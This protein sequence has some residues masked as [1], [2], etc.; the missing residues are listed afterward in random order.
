MKLTVLGSYGPYP[1][2]GGACPGYLLEHEGYAVLLEC[3]NGVISRLQQFI[4]LSQLQAIVIS[5]L[6]S[7]H[8]SDLFILR[9]ALQFS[10]ER[11]LL[12]RPLPIFAPPEPAGEYL[13]LPYKD[14]YA[15]ETLAEGQ[16]LQLGPFT[17]LFLETK[18]PVLCYAMAISIQGEK[19]LVYSADTEY[20]PLLADFA[21]GATLFLCEANLLEEDL[22][23]GAANHLS[24]AQAATLARE[25]GVEALL[26]THLH[27]SREPQL[28]LD[29]AGQVFENVG[30]AQEGVVYD[31]DRVPVDNTVTADET[32]NGLPKNWQQLTVKTDSIMASILAGRLKEEGIPVFLKKDEAAGGI[33]G[34]TTGPLANIRIFVPLSKIDQAR[35]LLEDIER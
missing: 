14:L 8:C 2:A 22:Q 5:H 10:R 29:E 32:E 24:A 3:G 19:R 17:F 13:R 21:R 12:E 33:Y 27:P 9:Y 23:K 34:L 18:H 28:Y 35:R 11:G 1:A 31:L 6:H 25:A 30:I 20:F 26:L 7:D 16:T 4:E 15:V